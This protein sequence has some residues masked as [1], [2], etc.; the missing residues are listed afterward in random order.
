MLTTQLGVAVIPATHEA[1]A[2][3]L[4]VQRQPWKRSKTPSQ[5]KKK[6]KKGQGFQ[7]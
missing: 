5:N 7:W 2:S 6:I 4:Q 3:G 1:K